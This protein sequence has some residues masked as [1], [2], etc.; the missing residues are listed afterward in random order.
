MKNG[1]RGKKGRGG[2]KKA[3]HL[4]VNVT[5]TVFEAFQRKSNHSRI[6]LYGESLHMLIAKEKTR[7]KERKGKFKLHN[8]CR[9]R[10][11]GPA[12]K[13]ERKNER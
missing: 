8:D 3:D 10:A 5:T 4:R 2:V 9:R 13:I 11:I 12:G 1:V 6:S 7:Q